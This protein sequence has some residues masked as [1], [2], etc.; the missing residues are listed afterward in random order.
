MS[1]FQLLRPLPKDLS[2][3]TILDSSFNPP[4]IAHL[5]LLRL[6]PPPYL[7][8]HSTTNADKGSSS[9]VS[10][11]RVQLMAAFAQSISED[12]GIAL[13]GEPYFVP[14]S[15]LVRDALGMGGKEISWVVGFDTVVRIYNERYYGGSKEEMT[16][17]L[18]G[19]FEESNRLVCADRGEDS[20]EFWRMGEVRMAV[21]LEWLLRRDAVSDAGISSTVSPVRHAVL[22]G[23]WDLVEQICGKEVTK[24]VKELKLYQS[25]S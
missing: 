13:V 20:G 6:C 9:S 15:K 19:F 25:A 4:T 11:N 5:S 18:Q 14:K 1:A 3:L 21:E 10:H 2:R 8:L 17:Q 16:Q 22:D 23:N 12:V 7:L 24:V